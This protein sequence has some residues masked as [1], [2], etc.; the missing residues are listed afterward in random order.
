MLTVLFKQTSGIV[1]GLLERWYAERKQL[2]AKKKEATDPEQIAFIGTRDSLKDSPITCMA[3][4]NHWFFDKRITT[5]LTGRATK[6][7][8]VISHRSGKYD[9]WRYDSME[10]QTCVSQ[11]QP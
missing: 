7:M 2:Q 10:I 11:C 6:H 4:F 8:G 9:H 5:P 1:P 3:L